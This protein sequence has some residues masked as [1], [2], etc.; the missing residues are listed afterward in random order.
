[1]VTFSEWLLQEM[2]NRNLNQKQLADDAGVSQSQVS[3][4]LKG[5]VKKPDASI[6]LRL[7][8]AWNIPEEEALKA[9]GYDKNFKPIKQSTIKYRDINEQLQEEPTDEKLL[10]L[11]K[12][13]P[14]VFLDKFD[15]LDEDE[16]L[17]IIDIFT[18]LLDKKRKEK[19]GKK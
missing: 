7:T 13:F 18:F 5:Y 12:Y 10:R 15:E 17:D 16:K 11:S 2:R 6:L 4:Y 9:G 1:M 14:E 3:R 19:E 8:K